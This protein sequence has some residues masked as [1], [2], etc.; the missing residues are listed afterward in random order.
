MRNLAD[1]PGGSPEWVTDNPASAARDFATG[2]P[3]FVEQ[4]PPWP[5]HSG[6]ITGNVTY[7]PEGWLKRVS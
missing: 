6:E 2:H 3:E 1:V 5:F 7:W 4:Q